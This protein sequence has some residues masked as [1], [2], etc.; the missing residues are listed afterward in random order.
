MLR[1]VFT[2][3]A[4]FVVVRQKIY[5]FITFCFL[6][7]LSDV[8]NQNNNQLETGIGDKKLSVELYVTT[9][10]KLHPSLLN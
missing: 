1:Y 4:F 10:V 7:N 6:D 2:F 5:V 8:L 3:W 9:V